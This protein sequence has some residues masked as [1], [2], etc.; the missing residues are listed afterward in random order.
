VSSTCISVLE[1]WISPVKGLGMLLVGVAQV[2]LP[3]LLVA[4]PGFEDDPE[5]DPAE[6]AAQRRRDEEHAQRLMPP[7]PSTFGPDERA[8]VFE[9][10]VS[11]VTYERRWMET[12]ERDVHMCPICGF[13]VRGFDH[14]CGII[15]ACIGRGTMPLFIL[16]LAST[17]ALL[18]CGMWASI[19]TMGLLLLHG[20]LLL[21]PPLITVGI[22]CVFN[23]FAFYLGAYTAFLACFYTS[24]GFR[25][26]FSL[27]R[28]RRA[29]FEENPSARSHVDAQPFCRSTRWRWRNLADALAPLL[30]LRLATR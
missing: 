5:D 7:L 21:F 10:Q 19:P 28:R 13:R 12:V 11:K 16:F 23:I 1:R 3:L 15:G 18:A 25:G 27:G 6:A 4:D 30:E 17:A 2:L 9:A 26:D 14:H 20:H 29:K 22:T 8:N 24:L